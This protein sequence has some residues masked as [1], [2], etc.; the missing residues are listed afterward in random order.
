MIASA[1]IGLSDS[2]FTTGL[3]GILASQNIKI[4]SCIL[5]EF[6]EVMDLRTEKYKKTR[7][8]GQFERSTLCHV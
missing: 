6:V 8:S 5:D 7:D 2:N 1:L 4:E 3:T